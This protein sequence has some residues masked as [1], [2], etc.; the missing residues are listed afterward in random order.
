[1][2][3]QMKQNIIENEKLI[4]LRDTLL[5]KLINREIHIDIKKIGGKNGF[6]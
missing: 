1:M 2:F 6:I 3:K 5:P 4:S